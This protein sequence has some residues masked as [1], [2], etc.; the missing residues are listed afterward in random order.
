MSNE[1]AALEAEVKEYKLQVGNLNT[2]EVVQY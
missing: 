2:V 1:I